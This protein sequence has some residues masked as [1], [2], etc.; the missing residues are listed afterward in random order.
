MMTFQARVLFDFT[1]SLPGELSVKAGDAIAV[2]NHDLGQGWLAGITEDGVEGFLPINYVQ[3][4]PPSAPLLNNIE[5]YHNESQQE[6]QPDRKTTPEEEQS[7]AVAE[8]RT[9]TKEEAGLGSQVPVQRFSSIQKLI[10][11]VFGKSDEVCAFLMG[12]TNSPEKENEE[13]INVI[14]FSKGN[15]QW[16]P[17]TE[18][19]S[20]IVGH[21]NRSSKFGGMKPLTTYSITPCFTDSQ[22]LRRYKHFEWLHERLVEKFGTMIAI[23]SLPRR[24]V[25]G[26]ADEDTLEKRRIQLQSF[27]DRIC[28]HPVLSKAAVW[29]HFVMEADENKWTE[30]KRLAEE[31]KNVKC[32]LLA[33]IQ[34]VEI[35]EESK[36]IIDE[37]ILEFTQEIKE[38]KQ[39]TAMMISTSKEQTLRYTK[40][41]SK[42][43]RDIGKAFYQI[44]FSLTG[45]KLSNFIQIGAVYQELSSLWVEQVTKDWEPIDHVMQE[46]KGLT[47]GWQVI[48]KLFQNMKEK[49]QEILQSDEAEEKKSSAVTRMNKYRIA[50]E[51]ERQFFNNELITGMNNVGRQFLKEQIRFRGKLV[52]KLQELFQK[53]NFVENDEKEHINSSF[54]ELGNSEVFSIEKL[55]DGSIG[56][57]K[58]EEIYSCKVEEPKR[59]SK[60]GGMKPFTIYQVT[61]SFTNYKVYRR[62]KHFDW[63]HSRLQAKFG[64]FIPIPALPNKQITGR[65]EEEFI[66]ERMSLLKAFVDRICRHPV[67]SK[68]DVWK[69][70]LVQVD[71]KEWKEGKRRAE[72]DQNVGFAL[73]KSLNVSESAKKD[74]LDLDKKLTKFEEDLLKFLNGVRNMKVLATEQRKKNRIMD[75][76]NN[77]KIGESFFH[78]GKTLESVCPWLSL[79]GTFYSSLAGTAREEWENVE[80]TMHMYQGLAEGWEAL[81]VEYQK[82][83]ENPVV[84][85]DKYKIALQAEATFFTQELSAE[86]PVMAKVGNS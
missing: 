43:F 69:H 5:E 2:T 79:A 21:A 71:D 83:K 4:Y 22:V 25:I 12:I 38:L 26:I 73:L 44:G 37:K 31:D 17:T 55:S 74:S 48:L 63:L 85:K 80:N 62:Y 40:K 7:D 86:L 56:W 60:Y 51:S 13:N 27:T 64:K 10:T 16:A 15:F 23:P 61:P 6:E 36:N 72:T 34:S 14:E 66:E 84:E 54:T 82:E 42:N 53:C 20:C 11:N 57:E 50:V 8:I 28:R 45:G 29:K 49:Q 81:L 24:P 47:E 67:L 58:L 75:T 18:A 1:G 77:D 68:A 52:E 76:K 32:A 3:M 19:F 35:S 70:F 65:F 78:L 9:I 39:S 41:Q 59:S 30:G 33:T 46:F